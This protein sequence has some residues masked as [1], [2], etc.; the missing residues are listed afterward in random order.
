MKRFSSLTS[1]SGMY[2][3][4]HY[5]KIRAAMQQQPAPSKQKLPSLCFCRF[6][7]LF[8]AYSQSVRRLFHSLS[9]WTSVWLS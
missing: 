5:P 4:V 1:Q 6:T 3:Y 7:W 9:S 2:F 8:I